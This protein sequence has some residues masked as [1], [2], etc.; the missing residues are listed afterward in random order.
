MGRPRIDGGTTSAQRFQ[1]PI[2]VPPVIPDADRQTSMRLTLDH[3][4][5]LN[6][7]HA[8]AVSVPTVGE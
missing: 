1:R 7:G 8:V 2:D 6:N 4:V 5:E 3:M